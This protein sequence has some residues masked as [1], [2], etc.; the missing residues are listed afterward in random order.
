MNKGEILMVEWEDSYGVESGW[1][2]ISDYSAS[3][4]IIKSVGIV[5]YE[6]DSIISLAHNFAD[7]TEHTPK[8]AN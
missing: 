8:Q 2:D 1:Q 5:S 3:V 4:L 6:D 7:E